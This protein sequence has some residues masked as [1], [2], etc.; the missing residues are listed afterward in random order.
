MAQPKRHTEWKTPLG[1]NSSCPASTETSQGYGTEQGLRIGK[2]D[3]T[4]EASH[5]A[6]GAV[7]TSATPAVRRGHAAHLGLRGGQPRD[8][9]Q[10]QFHLVLM[11][12]CFWPAAVGLMDWAPTTSP[13]ADFEHHL[14]PELLQGLK[15]LTQV[16]SSVVSGTALLNR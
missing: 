1:G 13:E 4:S 15:G 8:L 16:K 12:Q 7:D 2:D 11:A 14:F 10:G 9:L 6:L 5:C 3:F